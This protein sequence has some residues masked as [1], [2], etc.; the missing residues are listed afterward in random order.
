VAGGRHVDGE[1]IG[2]RYRRALADLLE[3]L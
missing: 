1:A 3:G 2:I